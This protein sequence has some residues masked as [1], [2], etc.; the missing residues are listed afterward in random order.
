MGG[1]QGTWEERLSSFFAHQIRT[2]PSPVYGGGLRA[3]LDAF[4]RLGLPALLA[5]VRSTGAVPLPA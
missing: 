4:Q 1:V 2:D 3:A 5:H